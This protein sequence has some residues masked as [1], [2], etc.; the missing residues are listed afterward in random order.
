MSQQG[1]PDHS[2]ADDD[3]DPIILDAQQAAN[4]ELNVLPKLVCSDYE[5]A[6]IDERLRRVVQYLIDTERHRMAALVA[7]LHVELTA[8]RANAGEVAK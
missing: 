3:D 4:V 6:G 1:C 8:M 7:D 5:W 2:R